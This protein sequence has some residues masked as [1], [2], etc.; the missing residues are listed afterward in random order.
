MVTKVAGFHF[1]GCAVCLRWLFTRAAPLHKM[2]LIIG[3]IV[4]EQP[5]LQELHCALSDYEQLKQLQSRMK[6]IMQ[7]MAATH[8]VEV[9]RR[10]DADDGDDDDDDDDRD[11]DDDDDDDVVVDDDHDDVD[12]DAFQQYYCLLM[13]DCRRRSCCK[14]LLVVCVRRF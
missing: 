6:Q 14:R 9:L 10:L 1:V 5:S 2:L 7:I 4:N 3:A 12:D 13:D 8:S 11:D